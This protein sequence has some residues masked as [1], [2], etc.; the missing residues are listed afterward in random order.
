MKDNNNYKYAVIIII[1]GFLLRLINI[2]DPILEVA[3]WRQCDTA[4]IAR[5]FYNYGMNIF[6]PQ[7][8]EGGLINAYAGELEFQIY[9][10]TVAV[11]YKLF[12]VHEYLGRLVSITAFCGGAFFLYKL[13][14]KYFDVIPSLI[15]L[16]FYTFNPYM[17]FY[18]RSFQPDSSMI[19]FSIA[20]L[21]FFS[22]WIDK[23]GL[24]RFVLMT[25]CAA[26]A[27]LIKLP[28]VCL[29][30]PLLYLCIKKYRYNLIIQ[31]KLWLFAAL[32]LVP[33]VLWS[34]HSY[35][36]GQTA[37]GIPIGNYKLSGLSTY[38]DPHFYYRVFYAEIFESCLIYIGGIFFVLG[39]IFTIKK[40]ELRYIHYWLLAIII[41]FFLGG[42]GTAWH[43]YHTIT[44]IAPASLLIGYII[45]N[46]A[47]LI[48]E[49]NIT[50][51]TRVVLLALS[52]SMMVS[53]PLISYHKITG[54]YKAKR[55]EKDYPIYKVGKIVDEIIPKND[56]IIGSLWGG[57]EILYFS[58]RRGWAINTIGCSIESI[59]ALKKEGAKYF[60]TTA[61]EAMDKNLMNYLQYRCETIR[62]TNKYLIVKL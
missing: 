10:F 24:W 7:M 26:L 34:V 61:L 40:H 39:I 12:G 62:S 45:S 50:G 56:S 54:R 25:L 33:I 44:I 4:G 51:K 9:P 31:W 59:E 46:S 28:A 42:S 14:R 55:L 27:F 53:L 60:V 49:N 37:E 36:L 17:F 15:A 29:G 35:H 41:S 30:L 22:E 16:I 8:V 43:T 3:G 11:L 38:M 1:S 13:A 47:K 52:V 6:Y 23:E 21:Y 32:T 20:M 48:N 5:N 58:N 2:T 18:S 19:F 57:P